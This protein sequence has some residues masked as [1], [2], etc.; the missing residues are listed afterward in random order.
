[1]TGQD[2]RKVPLF[3]DLLPSEIELFMK[4]TGTTIKRY[5][6]GERVL[7]AFAPNANI[8]IIVSGEAQ[9]LSLDRLGNESVGH[10]L[11]SGAMFGTVSAILGEDLIATSVQL[12]T[13]AVIMWVPYRSLLIAGPKLGRMH[14]IVMKYLLE[15]FSRKNVM[16][17]QKVELLSQKNLRERIILYLL[18]RE[19]RQQSERVKVPGRVQFAK[20]L[21]CNR[22]SLTR[23]ISQMEAEGLVEVGDKWMRLNKD[24]L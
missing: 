1:M 24:K 8:G 3:K 5:P 19:R 16:M 6:R 4:F 10:S 7:E 20:E 18:Q 21:E 11:E 2:L 23:E 22:S 13:E 14:G 12:T 9:I 15:T 17:M